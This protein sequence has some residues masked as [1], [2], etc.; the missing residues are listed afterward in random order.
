MIIKVSAKILANVDG[1]KTYKPVLN[2]SRRKKMGPS[3]EDLER[4][5]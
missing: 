2:L 3:F 1:K 5:G 4:I